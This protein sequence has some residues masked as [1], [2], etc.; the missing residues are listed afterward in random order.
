MYLTLYLRG[1]KRELLIPSG[2]AYGARGAGKVIPPGASL[3]FEVEL[4]D[5]RNQH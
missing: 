4:L 5:I 1:G 2:L 3:V